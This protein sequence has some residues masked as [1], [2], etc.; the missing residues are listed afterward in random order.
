MAICAV[1]ADAADRGKGE[2]RGRGKREEGKV[3]ARGG[4]RGGWGKRDW[5]RRGGGDSR[6]Y[7]YVLKPQ[8][9]GESL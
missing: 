5:G 4:G 8:A 1:Q 7:L 3:G 9:V 6:I 2:R